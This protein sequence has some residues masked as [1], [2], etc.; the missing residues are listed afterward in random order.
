MAA[1]FG[2]RSSVISHIAEAPAAIDEALGGDGPSLCVVYTD[3][4]Q[5]FVP[6]LSVSTAADGSLVS[7]PLEDLA[8]LLPREQ[9]AR[10]MIV[11]VHPKSASLAVEEPELVRQ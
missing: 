11:G 4:E 2:L 8:P 9:L 3:P 5:V 6:K 1:A 7:P 10:E